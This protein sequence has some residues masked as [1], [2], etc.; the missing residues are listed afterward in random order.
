LIDQSR[1]DEAERAVALLLS[2][3]PDFVP[4]VFAKARLLERKR[5]LDGAAAAAER[6]LALA[7]PED[8]ETCR[9]VHGLP[10][11]VYFALGRMEKAKEHQDWIEEHQKQ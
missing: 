2:R 6:V 5:D 1:N 11:R 8:A 7:P 9:S 3:A 4:A 10:A